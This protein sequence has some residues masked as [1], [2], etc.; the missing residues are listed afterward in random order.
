MISK[1]DNEADWDFVF[2]I[3]RR[4]KEKQKGNIRH[5]IENILTWPFPAFFLFLSVCVDVFIYEF[6][7]DWVGRRRR[8]KEKKSVSLSIPQNSISHDDQNEK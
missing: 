2:K 3:P 4:K 5:Q 8:K 7:N 6:T 1:T